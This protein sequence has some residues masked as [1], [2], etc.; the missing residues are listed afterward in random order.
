M[1][2][3]LGF[4]TLELGT[5][6][7]GTLGR[8]TLGRG[9]LGC[10]TPRRG[11]LGRGTIWHGTQ[12]QDSWAHQQILSS[13]LIS[14]FYLHVLFKIIILDARCLWVQYLKYCSSLYRCLFDWLYTYLGYLGSVLSR[15]AIRPSMSC[16][17]T[18]VF[19]VTLHYYCVLLTHSKIEFLF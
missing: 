4:R 3:Y 6:E 7:C 17:S 9:I 18:A 2:I 1:C 10:G 16:I 8:R 14:N 5:L 13:N 15:S 19:R 11:T 12:K